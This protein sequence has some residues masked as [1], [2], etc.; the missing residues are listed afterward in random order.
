MKG[1]L[2]SATIAAV[3]KF[4]L[5]ALLARHRAGVGVGVWFV[6]RRELGRGLLYLLISGEGC[7]R[8]RRQDCG[9]A[10]S[11]VIVGMGVRVR[12]SANVC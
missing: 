7:C 8:M 2:A 6:S 9:E 1:D 11:I 5:F 4:R 10:S 12:G 3:G